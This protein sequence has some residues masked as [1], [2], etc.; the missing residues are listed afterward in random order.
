MGKIPEQVCTL[1]PQYSLYNAALEWYLRL[2]LSYHLSYLGIH[3]PRNRKI[4]TNTPCRN[5]S[6]CETPTSQ[7][8][9]GVDSVATETHITESEN[10]NSSE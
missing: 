6:N 9:L 8:H 3:V 7:I 2:S 1:N 4:S 5:Y 10:V